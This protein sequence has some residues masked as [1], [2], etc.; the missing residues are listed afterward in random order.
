MKIQTTRAATAWL[1]CITKRM[2]VED[3][4]RF[5]KYNSMIKTLF[6]A[7]ANRVE[8]LLDNFIIVIIS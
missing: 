2:Q 5:R 6:A 4:N 3:S 7:T 8:L 1:T